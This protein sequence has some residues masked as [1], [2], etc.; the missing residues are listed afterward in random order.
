MK[1]APVSS[2]A[3]GS[4]LLAATKA[5]SETTEL[6]SAQPFRLVGVVRI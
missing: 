5:N 3:L 2:P 6:Y 1:F 4:P